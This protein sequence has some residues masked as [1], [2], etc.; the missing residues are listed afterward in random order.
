MNKKV[1]IS[2]LVVIGLILIT[3]A[4][5]L[6]LGGE[7]ED[8][9]APAQTCNPYLNISTIVKTRDLK[10]CDCLTEASQREMC[11]TNINDA[12][13]FSRGVQRSDATQCANI[14]DIGMKSACENLTKSK[15]LSATTSTQ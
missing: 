6:L 4:L 5:V 1:L 3:L 7:K 10:S 15:T 9:V 13:Y 14:K 12:I 2:T 11:Q 8:N